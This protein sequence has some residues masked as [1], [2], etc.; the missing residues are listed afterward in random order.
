[1]KSQDT[2]KNSEQLQH[3]VHGQINKLGKDL[4]HARTRLS[5]GS[6]LDDAIFYP[7]GQ[8]LTEAYAHLKENP[9]GTMFLSLGTL[10]L[11]EDQKR[12]SYESHLKSSMGAAVDKGKARY[13]EAEEKVSEKASEMADQAR[14]KAHSIKGRFQSKEEELKSKSE[15]TNL[16]EK[17]Q[18]LKER[19]A[20]KFEEVKHSASERYQDTKEKLES[21]SV[22]EVL[23]PFAIASMGLGL[24]ATLGASF[25]IPAAERK[26]RSEKFS[27]QI[28]RFGKDVDHA[29]KESG[30]KVKNHLIDE[31]KQFNFH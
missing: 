19:G 31:L 5:P 2:K 14:D 29:I 21:S 13:H 4:D 26:L 15:E 10:L 1:M 8:N 25:P 12:V 9:M 22:G 24:G 16:K 30:E 23:H 28:D 11:M 27:Q 20:E 18:D 7:Q 17:A 6:L 3:E